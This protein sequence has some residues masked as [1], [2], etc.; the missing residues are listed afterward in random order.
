MHVYLLHFSKPYKHVQHYLGATRYSMEER[1][2]RHH[3]RRGAKLLQA[4]F[5]AGIEVRIARIWHVDTKDEAFQLE[6]ELK[7]RKRH[8]DFCFF[9]G[10]RL[11]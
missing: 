10:G 9:C 3:N 4:V 6:I 2:K 11:I 8:K 7:K 5:A 1:M